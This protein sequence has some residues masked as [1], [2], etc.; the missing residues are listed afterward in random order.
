M[1]ELARD[2]AHALDA[3]LWAREALGLGPDPW[4]TRVLR[5][6]AGD[7]LLNCCRQSGKS[8]VAAALALHRALFWPGALV[9][10]LSPS[11]RQSGELFRR[12]ADFYRALCAPVPADAESALRLE[13]ANGSRVLSL[14]G[15]ERTVRGYS[16]AALLIVDEAARV[17]DSLYH[18][19]RPMLAVSRGR[20]LALSTPYGK[21]GWWYAAWA[22]GGD[23]WQRVRLTADECPRIAPEFLAAERRAVPAWVYAQEYD[24]AFADDDFAVF[25]TE[26]IRAALSS[27]VA[28]LFA[29]EG[30]DAQL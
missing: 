18:A 29:G 19:V 26:D 3:S 25:R 6:A 10:C 21:R 20:I 22:E 14:P 2:L 23:A 13:L 1:A 28:P 12:V 16:G 5:A 9:L 30:G 27:A 15:T 8:T 4:Q 11:L 24:C 7:W 17:A